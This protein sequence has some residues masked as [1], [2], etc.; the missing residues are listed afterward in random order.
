LEKYLKKNKKMQKNAQE[1]E[2]VTNPNMTRPKKPLTP[3]LLYCN[4]YRQLIKKENPDMKITEIQK[5]LGEMWKVVEDEE[6]KIYKDK[7]E[8]EN[9]K[10]KVLMA[11]FKE[12]EKKEKEEDEGKNHEGKKRK[13]QMDLKYFNSLE[14]KVDI[15]NKLNIDMTKR[16][17]RKLQ[18]DLNYLNSL[19]K[20]VDIGNKL[21]IDMTKHKKVKKILLID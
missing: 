4:E 8:I 12:D 10:W 11:K 9:E 3:F 15:G 1:K 16:K 20:M 13:L 5:L 6:K 18:M 14:K 2:K 19:E 17:K 21:N 7:W